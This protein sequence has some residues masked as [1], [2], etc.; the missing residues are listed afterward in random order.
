MKA[1]YFTQAELEVMLELSGG[2]AHTLYRLEPPPDDA[3]LIEAFASLYQRGFLTRT[4]SGLTPTARGGFFRDISRAPLAVALTMRHL[5]E[6]AAL[7]YCD[8]ETVWVCEYL[9]T[10]LSTRTR[11][12]RIPVENMETWLFETEILPPPV[13]TDADAGE[14][15]RTWSG[16]TNPDSLRLRLERYRNGGELLGTY[17]VLSGDGLPLIRS[18]QGGQTSVSLY[19]VEA[20]RAMLAHCFRKDS[21]QTL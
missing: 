19:T 11:L 14:C 16:E 12:S 4:E 7:C 8:G 18:R 21:Y 1:L 17:E 9:R 5:R 6:R 10:A 13:L 3:A 2:A 15:L 20:L